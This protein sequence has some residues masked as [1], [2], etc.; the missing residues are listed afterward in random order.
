M[1]TKILRITA[2]TCHPTMKFRGFFTTSKE[3]IGVFLYH[4]IEGLVI[5]TMF[6]YLVII[7]FNG[8]K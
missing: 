4:L 2:E 1:K 8:S 3:K 6:S 5:W 7:F